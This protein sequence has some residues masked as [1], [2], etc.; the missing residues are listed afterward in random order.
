M[1]NYLYRSLTVILFVSF[2][3]AGCTPRTKTVSKNNVEWD[4]IHIE[5]TY[6]L[7]D[8]PNNPSCNLQIHF[9][10]PFKYENKE[11]LEAIQRHFLRSSFGDSYENLTPGGAVERY[12]EL[13]LDDYKSLES[14][15]LAEKEKGHKHEEHEHEYE[16]S[17]S[18]FSYYEELENEI[19]YDKNDILCYSVSYEKYTGG[20]HGSHA[21]Y[22]H[23]I[24]LAT[25]LEIKEK[26]IFT[27]GYQ[28]PLAEILVNKIA[29]KNRLK[30]AK[31]LEE[32]GF[33]SIDEIYPND[34][35][36]IDDTGLTY[37]FNEYEIAAYVIGMTQVHLPYGEIK[38]L[39]RE[40]NKIA[41]LT[42]N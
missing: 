24:D 20:A 40:D 37:Y 26:D 25:G 39:L 9:I 12:V 7:Q 22:K 4:S 5:K 27:E 14:D 29:E 13:Y 38:H 35:F 21:C 8:D 34:N 28:E 32:I 16:A 6:H 42:G 18:W 41:L 10:F 11:V 15:F 2:W 31:E 17:N 3:L 36:S 33:F 19:L 1:K 23:V 30:N